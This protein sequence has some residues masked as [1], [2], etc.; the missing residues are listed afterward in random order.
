[1]RRSVRRFRRSSQWSM[2]T[3]MSDRIFFSLAAVAAV[4]MIALATVYP[5]GLGKRSPKP[6]GH[7]PIYEQQAAAAKA[8]PPAPPKAKHAPF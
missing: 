8:K 2:H 5:Q 7:T 3:A 1:M 4:A 6:F